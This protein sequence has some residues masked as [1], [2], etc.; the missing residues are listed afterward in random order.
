MRKLQFTADCK[1]HDHSKDN[2]CHTTQA[3]VTGLLS[4]Q[5]GEHG[6]QIA[7]VESANEQL[8]IQ[9]E[10]NPI[11][12]AVNCSLKNKQGVLVCE[13]SAHAN[14]EQDWFS[15]IE[16]QSVIKQLSQAVEETLKQDKSLSEFVWHK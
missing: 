3:Y 10:N 11:E 13:I 8:C 4:T 12:L 7:R 5:L 1:Q 9:V 15:K 2:V 6:F 16:T 14:E